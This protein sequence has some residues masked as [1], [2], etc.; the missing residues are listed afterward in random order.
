[1]IYV[2]DNE[3][4]TC[5]VQR[6]AYPGFLP[7]EICGNRLSHLCVETVVLDESKNNQTRHTFVEMRQKLM[8]RFLDGALDQPA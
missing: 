7:D 5:G 2:N 1:M 8:Q 3:I 4:N 6:G